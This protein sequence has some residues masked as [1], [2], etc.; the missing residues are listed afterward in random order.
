MKVLDAYDWGEENKDRF[1]NGS[2]VNQ[3]MTAYAKYY[4][5]AMIEHYYNW[6]GINL[7]R[8]KPNDHEH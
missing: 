5:E 1:P 6:D 8:K 7:E 2:N 3:I 4:H